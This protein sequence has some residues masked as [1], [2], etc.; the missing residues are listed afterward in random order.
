[1]DMVSVTPNLLKL[2]FVPLT[3][4]TCC[5][6]YDSLILIIQQRQSV[7]HWKYNVVMY[8][9]RA[10]A[11]LM[12]KSGAFH[13]SILNP[14]T[15]P[16]ASHGESQVERKECNK[17]WPNKDLLNGGCY[18]THQSILYFERNLVLPYQLN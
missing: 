12:N 1:M 9:P 14:K 11:S 8:L 15:V 5:L 2:N 4:F 17:T 7:F 18:L 13:P 10:M 3:Y 16:V 6:N